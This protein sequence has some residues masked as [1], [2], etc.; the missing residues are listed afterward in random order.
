[1][2]LQVPW[3]GWNE[4][5]AV[6]DMLFSPSYQLA[7]LRRLEAWNHRGRVP[8]AVEA[9]AALIGAQTMDQLVRSMPRSAQVVLERQCRHSYALAILRCVN[10]MV[11]PNQKG[12]VAISVSCLADKMQ[13]PRHLVD[14]RHDATH[15]VLP[16]LQVLRAAAQEAVLWLKENYWERQRKAVTSSRSAIVKAVGRYAVD[17]E[18]EEW[19]EQ[20]AHDFVSTLQTTGTTPDSVK[21]SLVPELLRCLVGAAL[22]QGALDRW[23]STIAIM[24]T[25]LFDHLTAALLL[26]GVAELIA[27][28][29]IHKRSRY[30]I[31]LGR[32]L[33]GL[34]RGHPVHRRLL[35]ICVSSPNPET[36]AVAEAIL[37]KQV[38][39]DSEASSIRGVF[40][41]SRMGRKRKRCRESAGEGWA[42]ANNW[43]SRPI[44][45]LANGELPDLRINLDDEA[46]VG[47]EAEVGALGDGVDAG[48]E[49]IRDDVHEE[50]ANVVVD[51]KQHKEKAWLESVKPGKLFLL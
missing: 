22:T 25:E 17:L 34:D 46:G 49:D 13:L 9:S 10:G 19:D 11:D 43:V 29:D 31:V 28:N 42:V 24:A 30:A 35:L 14:L 21:S 50:E 7:G 6:C 44:G 16:S 40:E 37:Q 3:T 23:V 5:N 39:S 48:E 41:V 26:V 38:C 51:T 2:P 1:M 8:V 45:L 47:V 33:S 18:A 4:F 12:K 20:R 36:A 32:L 15:G 27:C